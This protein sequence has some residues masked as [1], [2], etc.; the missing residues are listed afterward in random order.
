M[1]FGPAGE[2]F[3][4]ARCARGEKQFL[5][6]FSTITSQNRVKT[7]EIV[8][9]LVKNAGIFFDQTTQNKSVV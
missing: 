1:T 7:V 9:K 8:T 5:G 3:R 6:Y 4:S 2:N